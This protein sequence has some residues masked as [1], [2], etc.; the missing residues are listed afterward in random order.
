[1]KGTPAFIMAE[2]GYNNV[3]YSNIMTEKGYTNVCYSNIMT[4]KGYTNVCYSNIMSTSLYGTPSN[5]ETTRNDT[6]IMLHVIIM[7]INTL[8]LFVLAKE[9]LC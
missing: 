4:E 8:V 6:P 3:C 2:K 5:E 9:I 7:G 1:M